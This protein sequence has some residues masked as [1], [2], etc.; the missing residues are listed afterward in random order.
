MLISLFSMMRA[1]DD[2]LLGFV[3]ILAYLIAILGAI[4]L[5]EFAHGVVAYWNG[6][7]TAKMSGRLSLNPAK[8][9]DP[10]GFL[11]L[12]LIGFGWA[13]P[14]PIDSRNFR[15]YKRGMIT[16]SIAGV[17][18]NV[19]QAFLAMSCIAILAAILG[20]T[21]VFESRNFAYYFVNF[22]VYL[23]QYSATVNLTLF[24]FNL[25]PIY[26]LDGFRVVETLAKPYNRYVEF[27]YRYGSFL[28][29]GLLVLSNVLG[30]I[31]PYLDILGLYMGAVSSAVRQ[32]FSLIL[33]M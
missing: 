14:V 2:K 12:A 33:G 28:L 8:H 27:N 31:S 29:L 21:V 13:K 19:I 20:D 7:Y 30:Y 17:V 5:H 10:I 18:C 15:N 9:F 24:A 4:I 25:I 3:A 26:P 1:M 32:L 11:M 23:L 6:D 22:T 16:T